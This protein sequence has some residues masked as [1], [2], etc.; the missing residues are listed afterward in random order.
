MSKIGRYF[1][2]KFNRNVEMKVSTDINKSNVS[3]LSPTLCH[4]NMSFM[5]GGKCLYISKLCAFRKGKAAKTFLPVLLLITACVVVYFPVLCNDFLNFWDDQWVVMNR[6]T[7]GGLC[8][9]NLWAILTE[10]YHGQY[11]PF[12]ELLY[13]IL[14]AISGY[15]PFV[16]HLTSLL[17][18]VANVCLVYFC[19]KLLITMNTKFKTENAGLVAFLTALIFAVHPFN[20]ESVAWMSAS[21]VLVYS[22][23]YLAATY[24]FLL[25]LKK[26][27][28]MYFV[29]TLFLFVFSFLGKEQA[30]TFPLWMLLIYWLTGHGFKN[31][32]V[33]LTVVPFLILSLTFGLITM[34]SQTNGV[35]LFS[36]NE[37]YPLW[38]RVVYA[39][40][41]LTEY[42]LKSVFPFKLSYLYP[43]PS[44]VGE[45]LP[46]WLLIYP[47]I[48]I[49]LT[50]SFWKQI[51]TNR[52]LAFS[53][54]FF[55]IHIAVA[56]HI[57][58]L[59]R[60]AVVAD[61][62]AY[63]AT[64]GVCFAFSFY[65]VRFLKEKRKYQKPI[66]LLLMGYLLYFGVY[67]NIR[68]RVWHDTDTLK[69][70][71]RELL[72]ERND[73][74]KDKEM[75]FLNNIINQKKFTKNEKN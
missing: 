63:I 4:D 68:S 15:N 13:L 25:Y 67:T 6:Y 41:T 32:T 40:Y 71:I 64:L 57:I 29:F 48:I 21:K 9:N 59:S 38:Q 14:Y 52:V 47:L 18:H 46:E 20:V 36:H 30:V 56:L 24:C 19:F 23:Y 10:F 26:E 50:I 27:K 61:R 75:V 5:G 49:I 33:W 31:K 44:V 2:A 65:A 55:L 35:S 3:S 60:F 74:E 1:A 11:A 37:G 16:F 42:I 51:T 70:E 34:L 66:A 17:L 7:E 28:V 45:P 8:L 39:C 54:L 12:N 43:F 58:S 69:H 62:Y 73:Y 72:K 53:L 22:F